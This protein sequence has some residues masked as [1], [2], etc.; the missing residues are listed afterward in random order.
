MSQMFYVI[1]GN[2]DNIFAALWN[3]DRAATEVINEK[4]LFFL[5]LAKGI[6]AA[7]VEYLSCYSFITHILWEQTWENAIPL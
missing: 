3:C 5:S 7:F 4:Y 6:I 2:I 1:L